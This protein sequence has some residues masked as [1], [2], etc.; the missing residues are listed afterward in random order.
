MR[1][2]TWGDSYYAS[3]GRGCVFLAQVGEDYK[4]CE[5]L[6]YHARKVRYDGVTQLYLLQII[7]SSYEKKSKLRQRNRTLQVQLSCAQL[8]I[9][10]NVQVMLESH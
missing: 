6:C 2:N 4:E 9:E 10:M 8:S 1:Y 7:C 5:K 3:V